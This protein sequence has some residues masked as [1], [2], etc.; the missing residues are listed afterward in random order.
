[1]GQL[2]TNNGSALLAASITDLDTTIQVAAGFGQ[3]F[4]SPGAGE[5]ALVTLENADG[6]IEI[7][8]YTTRSTDLL[9]NCTRGMEGTTAQSWTNGVTRVES[10]LTK[11]TMEAFLQKTGGEMS[12]DVDM[13]G[14]DL[15]D[16]VL[17]GSGAKM[18]GGEIVGVP[19]R[20]VSGDTSN[21]ISVPNDGTRATAGGAAILCA[22]DDL[23]DDVFTVGMVLL[24]YGSAGTVPEGFQICDGTNGTPDLRDRFVVGAGSSYALGAS[25]GAASASGSTDSG[26]SHDHTGT[27]AGHALTAAEMPAH[28]HRIF[29]VENSSNSNADGWGAS[30]VR[31]IP[32]EDVGPFAY[33]EDSNSGDQLIEDAGSGDAHT[34]SLTINSDGAHTHTLSGISVLPPYRALYYIMRV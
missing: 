6:D 4:P 28:N 19:L 8:K 29:A 24:W 31:G 20:G 27:A 10:R 22:G 32:G 17:S 7:V 14:N 1:M 33:R 5:F 21:Q 34:H 3:F 12:G 26:G 11:G 25:G 15:I 9:Q 23:Y 30:G 18:T 13:N 16:G 2:F